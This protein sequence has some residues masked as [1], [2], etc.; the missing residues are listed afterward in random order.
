MPAG[1]CHCILISLSYS[2]S[3][4]LILIVG[5]KLNQTHLHVT[6]CRR[7]IKTPSRPHMDDDPARAYVRMR[8]H[9]PSRVHACAYPPPATPERH[10]AANGCR[11]LGGGACHAV[12]GH[13]MP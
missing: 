9:A 11:G 12:G 5:K 3:V 1:H 4:I 7:R 2:Y 8:P 6:G 10:V 13:A